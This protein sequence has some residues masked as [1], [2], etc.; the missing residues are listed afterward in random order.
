MSRHEIT[1]K[2]WRKING[3]LPKAKRGRGR[4]EANLRKTLNGILYVLRTGCAWMDMPKKYGS[5]TTC[6]RR[7]RLYSKLRIWDRIWKWLLRDLYE[8]KKIQLGIAHVDA[9]FV[10]AKRGG[11]KIGKT[12]LG[13]GSKV[14]SV[15]EN[16][17]GLPIALLIEN[18]NPHE[19]TFAEKIVSEIR[20]PQKRGA[21][22]R[23]PKILVADKGYI[24]QAFRTY[25]RRKGI[26]V[27]IP[28]KKNQKP[29]KGLQPKDFQSS[30]KQ[31]FKVERSFAWMD[32]FRRLVVRYD[33][34]S[35]IYRGFNVLACIIMCLRH[36]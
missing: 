29:P 7:H 25:L 20:I 16:K 36:F 15:V 33:R 8:E 30:Y 32:N 11:D 18:A 26:L 28:F 12:K 5:Y 1:D 14:F 2:Q 3:Y 24:S 6:W 35:W 17:N 23:K 22:I 4:P 9:S 19:I 13:K 27:R 31:R 34:F 21:P 10:P